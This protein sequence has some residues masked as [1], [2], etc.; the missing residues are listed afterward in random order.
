MQGSTTGIKQDSHKMGAAKLAIDAF[1]LLEMHT[2]G[3]VHDE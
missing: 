1:E 2:R 3:T